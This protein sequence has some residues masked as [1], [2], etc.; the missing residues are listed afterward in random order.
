MTARYILSQ[1]WHYEEAALVHTLKGHKGE[2]T[3]IQVSPDNAIVASACTLGSVRLWRL[4]DGQCL[5]VLQHGTVQVNYLKFNDLTYTISTVGD[6]GHCVVWDLHRILRSEEESITQLKYMTKNR[7]QMVGDESGEKCRSSRCL[8]IVRRESSHLF[9]WSA[10]GDRLVLPHARLSNVLSIG[11]NE[12]KLKIYIL[13][14]HPVENVLVTGGEDGIARLWTFR[15]VHR[16]ETRALRETKKEMSAQGADALSKIFDQLLLSLEGHKDKISDTKFSNLGDRIVT[17]SDE[18]C[19]VRIWSF[20]K[21]T[22]AL[23][24]IITLYFTLLF[25]LHYIQSQHTQSTNMC[26]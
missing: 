7:V 26:L 24:S 21:C 12:S 19:T 14:V 16:R 22:H 17:G 20:D 3:I 15:D 5:K 10:T 4:V 18:D 2:I 13:D 9:D 11:N 25:L 6:D 8:E 23:L 1:V